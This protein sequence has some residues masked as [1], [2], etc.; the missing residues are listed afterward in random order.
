MRS[1]F[2]RRIQPL[3]GVCHVLHLRYIWM[4][5]GGEFGAATDSFDDWLWLNLVLFQYR[6]KLRC[7]LKQRNYAPYQDG[8]SDVD[9][10]LCRTVN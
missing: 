7:T 3:E 2:S 9:V 5:F 6:I 1:D 10:F 4:A 8:I